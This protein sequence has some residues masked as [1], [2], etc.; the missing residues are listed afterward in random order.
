MTKDSQ[1]NLTCITEHKARLTRDSKHPS[2][3]ADR[4]EKYAQA[5]LERVSL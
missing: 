1:I 2:T 4:L 3:T 5:K